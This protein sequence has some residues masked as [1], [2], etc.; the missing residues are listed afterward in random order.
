V[1]IAR[2]REEGADAQTHKKSAHALETCVESR[3]RARRRSVCPNK[4]PYYIRIAHPEHA[5]AR[6]RRARAGIYYVIARRG[7]HRAVE[8][9]GLQLSMTMV[10]SVAVDRRPHTTTHDAHGIRIASRRPRRC[11]E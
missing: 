7:A 6:T 2:R 11:R 9:L 1:P 3:T 8:V 10:T 4:T 5:Y